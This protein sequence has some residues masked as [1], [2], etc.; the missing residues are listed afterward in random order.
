M[1]NRP[2]NDLRVVST[3]LYLVEPDDV[4]ESIAVYIAGVGAAAI[5]YGREPLDVLREVVEEAIGYEKK[6]D[7][8]SYNVLGCVLEDMFHVSEFW[9]K[10]INGIRDDLEDNFEDIDDIRT[11]QACIFADFLSDAG[12]YDIAV[13][14]AL[15]GAQYIAKRYDMDTVEVLETANR[16]ASEVDNDV[17]GMGGYLAGE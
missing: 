1:S 3:M 13:G 9:E 17:G 12:S 8:A 10:E 16:I 6:G 2:F 14:C 4:A 11:W 5:S 7:D 15:L